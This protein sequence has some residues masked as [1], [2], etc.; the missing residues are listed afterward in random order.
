MAKDIGVSAADLSIWERGCTE[1]GQK[2]LEAIAK[3]K[4]VTLKQ[5]ENYL[6][7]SSFF[8]FHFAF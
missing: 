7:P 3:F 6:K 1:P 5:L 8:N 4:G 2:E